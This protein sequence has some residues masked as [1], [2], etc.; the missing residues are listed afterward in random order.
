MPPQTAIA[1]SIIFKISELTEDSPYRRRHGIESGADVV[2]VLRY[3]GFVTIFA[4]IVSRWVPAAPSETIY[5]N[6]LRAACE[7]E[8][9]D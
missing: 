2:W 7:P 3:G 4:A 5:V 6:E 9:E 8:G 1:A